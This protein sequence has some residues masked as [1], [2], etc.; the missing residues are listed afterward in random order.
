MKKYIATCKKPVKPIYKNKHKDEKEIEYNEVNFM[1]RM[2]WTTD[3]ENAFLS[4]SKEE[5]EVLMKKSL[6]ATYYR[7]DDTGELISHDIQDIVIHEIEI[8]NPLES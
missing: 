1:G 7:V 6:N 3:F 8:K 5:L 4:D 2:F